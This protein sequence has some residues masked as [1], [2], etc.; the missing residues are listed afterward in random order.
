MA[1][2]QGCKACWAITESTSKSIRLNL[3]RQLYAVPERCGL[4]DLRI[5]L[6]KAAPS[7][8]WS[9]TWEFQ[10]SKNSEKMEPFRNSSKKYPVPN[11]VKWPILQ[12][13]SCL[14]AYYLWRTCPWPDSQDRPSS[15]R[16]P[17]CRLDQLDL[18]ADDDPTMLAVAFCDTCSWDTHWTDIAL[19]KSCRIQK[20]QHLSH[21]ST[22][23]TQ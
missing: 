22:I 4:W 17:W 16:P 11:Q 19:A 23:L 10:P 14:W 8:G 12:K 3:S 21:L 15:W 20:S 18:P 7:S 2:P 6:I 13:R 9:Q 5:Q 1:I